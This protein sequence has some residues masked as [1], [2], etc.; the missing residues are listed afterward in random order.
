MGVKTA[1][2]KWLKRICGLNITKP[3]KSLQWPEQFKAYEE[4]KH[5]RYTLLF[6][7]TGGAFAIAQLLVPK[8]AS[9]QPAKCIDLKNLT[10]VK[11]SLGMML[12]TM[13]MGFDICAFGLKMRQYVPDAFGFPGRIVLVL[14][15][16][17]ICAGWFSAAGLGSTLWH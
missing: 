3:P 15:V 11:L 2:C 7:V 12:F 13:V 8:T 5:R 9:D 16:F 14:I 4:G 17:L 10:V 1:I 6:A